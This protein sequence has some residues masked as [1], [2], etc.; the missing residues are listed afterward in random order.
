MHLVQCC[1]PALVGWRFSCVYAFDGFLLWVRI[2]CGLVRLA[3][4]TESI[5]AKPLR[6]FVQQETQKAHSKTQSRPT[7]ADQ[8]HRTEAHE[9]GPKQSVPA[10]LGFITGAWGLPQRLG[11]SC[12]RTARV[13]V[14][15]AVGAVLLCLWLM[16]RWHRV[17]CAVCVCG[18]LVRC[19][20]G[21]VGG[22]PFVDR[23]A[24]PSALVA[25]R[26]LCACVPSVVSSY[27]F[28]LPVHP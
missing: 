18:V 19:M 20:C 23:P 4:D 1:W 3:L 2:A 21:L 26:L 27:S 9:Q 8:Q 28:L 12:M 5:H 11:F 15:P 22:L 10:S 14:A 6:L 13:P 7:R 24:A 17:R 16:P 25:W